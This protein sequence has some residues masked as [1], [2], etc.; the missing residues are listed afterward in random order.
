MNTPSTPPHHQTSPA[1]AA[2]AAADPLPPP[3]NNSRPPPPGI[4]ASRAPTRVRA[5][6]TVEGGHCRLVRSVTNTEQSNGGSRRSGDAQRAQRRTRTA[7]STSTST[8]SPCSPSPSPAPPP[9]T[10]TST[11][12]RAP[13]APGNPGSGAAIRVYHESGAAVAMV[14]RVHTYPAR[15]GCLGLLPCGP[16]GEPELLSA[17]AESIQPQFQQ[18]AI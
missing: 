6:A 15:S 5:P 2:A 13:R 14:V 1:A 4:K 18:T 10:P 11:A 12:P 16:A 7:A 9:T 8:A 3:S 17:A